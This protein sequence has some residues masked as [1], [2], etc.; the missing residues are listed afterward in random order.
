MEKLKCLSG[1]TLKIIAIVTMLIDHIG[2]CIWLRLPDLGYLVPE[3]MDRD[4]WWDIYI[5]L[6]QIGRTAFPLFCFLLVEG[7][8]HSKSRLKYA[9][10]LFAFCW[11]SQAPFYY[12]SLGLTEP[13]KFNVFFTLF[14]GFMAIWGMEGA[15][16][17][18]YKPHLF[19]PFWVLIAAGSAYLAFQL[20]TDYRHWGVLLIVAFYALHEWRVVAL[21]AGYVLLYWEPFCFPAFILAWFYNGKRGLK[22][23]YVFYI[24][25]PVHFVVLYVIWRYLL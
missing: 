7:F 21:V 19:L 18:W 8:M 4:K 22:L 20:D 3:V 13:M 12:A 17:L 10:R 14:I 16:R 24:F 5:A 6:R 1:S 15:R 2:L 25:Y 23:K 11:I 9:L